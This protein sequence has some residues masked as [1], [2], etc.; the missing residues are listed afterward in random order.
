M[1]ESHKKMAT[2]SE[3]APIAF[4]EDFMD[5]YT[6]D[7]DGGDDDDVDDDESS[8]SSL[9]T[10]CQDAQTTKSENEGLHSH[11]HDQIKHT[12]CVTI[13][14]I[15]NRKGNAFHEDYAPHKVLS[16]VLSSRGGINSE[17]DGECNS[18]TGSRYILYSSVYGSHSQFSKSSLRHSIEGI[19]GLKHEGPEPVIL[20]YVGRRCRECDTL[21][22]DTGQHSSETVYMADMAAGLKMNSSKDVTLDSL[23]VFNTI[24]GE[25]LLPD[26]CEQQRGSE[27]KPHEL[28]GQIEDNRAS[29]NKDKVK[30]TCMWVLKKSVIFS[31]SNIGLACIIVCYALLGAVIF[32]SLEAW[33]EKEVSS[34]I[35]DIRKERMEELRSIPLALGHLKKEAWMAKA[36]KILFKFQRKL[37]TM[38]K[39]FGW[40]GVEDA[41]ESEQHWSFAGALLYSVTL[42]TTIGKL[43]IISALPWELIRT[44]YSYVMNMVLWQLLV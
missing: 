32:Q 17:D 23:V 40:D 24:T 11:I 12:D 44:L 26:G 14:N 30:D 4:Q 41:V 10:S 5:Y 36:D 22:H 9:N 16:N 38:T 2:N 18:S 31:V 19:S 3:K 1:T 29:L 33:K 25:R 20:G 28:I 37:Y 21:S 42:I 34:T 13:A 35:W 27:D 7:G 43:L 8:F 39:E 15:E 6:C